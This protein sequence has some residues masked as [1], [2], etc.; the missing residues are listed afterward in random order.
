MTHPE[1]LIEI[2]YY[3]IENKNKTGIQTETIN[4]YAF[5][6]IDIKCAK[7][8]YRLAKR[9]LNKSIRYRINKGD[10]TKW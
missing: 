7:I 9:F 10:K 1:K 5:N 6:D 8:L 3:Y 2:K 4:L